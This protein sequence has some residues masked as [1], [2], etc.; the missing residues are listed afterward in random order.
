MYT[1]NAPIVKCPDSEILWEQYYQLRY[2]VLRKPWQQI[3]GSEIDPSD[4]T[5][6]HAAAILNDEIVA[7]GRLHLIDGDTAQIRY[8]AASPLMQGKGMGGKVLQYLEVEGKKQ[9]VKKIILQARENAI[10]FYLSH[11]YQ[12]TGDGILLFGVIPH[13]W[14]KKIL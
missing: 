7:V 6:T 14:M 12:I 8:M 5:S 1:E 2:E 9:G 10:N 4:E 11:G 3:E 13:K